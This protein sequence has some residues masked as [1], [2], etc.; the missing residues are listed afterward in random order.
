MD[1][2]WKYAYLSSYWNNIDFSIVLS[3]LWITSCELNVTVVMG[4]FL[5]KRVF[6]TS[7]KAY[8]ILITV[9]QRT[10]KYCCLNTCIPTKS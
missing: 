6:S 3:L 7:G 1:L 4:T 5:A 9:L 10:W 8:D 2:L